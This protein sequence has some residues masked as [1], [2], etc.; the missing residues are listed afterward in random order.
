MELPEI[1]LKIETVKVDVAKTRKLKTKYTL[2]ATQSLNGMNI[3][4]Q[5]DFDR[6]MLGKRTRSAIMES[7][8]K[9]RIKHLK[10]KCNIWSKI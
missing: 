5:E 8:E 3:S 10:N 4:G 1:D 9:R 7:L 2:N 6:A